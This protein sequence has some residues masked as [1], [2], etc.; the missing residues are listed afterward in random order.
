MS[1]RQLVIHIPHS[2][3]TV[4]AEARSTI[5]LS[6]EALHDE[7]ARMTDWFTDELFISRERCCRTVV[8]DTSRLVVDGERFPQDRD[9]PMVDRGMGAIYVKTSGGAR[10]RD[11]LTAAQRQAWINRWYYPHHETLTRY[12]DEALAIEGSCIVID[13]HSFPGQPLPYELDQ[14]CDRPD[15]CL[16]TD[17][18][19]TP[20]ELL[21]V[22]TDYFCSHGLSVQVNQPFAGCMVPAKHY[23]HTRAVAAIMVEVN[24]GCYLEEHAAKKTERFGEIQEI[25]QGFIRLLASWGGLPKHFD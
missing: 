7:I 6:D 12:V 10:L 14:R 16:G 15:I 22:A 17:A 21:K 5:V 3:V 19:H 8:A 24:R 1:P 23:R 20:S 25:T 4:P 2:S 13:G 18:F 9:E 11:A